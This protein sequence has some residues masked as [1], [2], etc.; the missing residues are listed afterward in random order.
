MA[1]NPR[2]I[3]G[4]PA[5]SSSELQRQNA[6]LAGPQRLVERLKSNYPPGLRVDQDPDAQLGASSGLFTVGA[7]LVQAAPALPRL[8]LQAAPP[9]QEQGD[10]GT[11]D[12]SPAGVEK[13]RDKEDPEA[14]NASSTSL[15]APG[16]NQEAAKKFGTANTF[17]AAH[18]TGGPTARRSQRTATGSVSLEPPP[19][20]SGSSSIKNSRARLPPVED[21]RPVGRKR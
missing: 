14:Y 5:R 1:S 10:V 4:E 8:T 20:V 19:S 13:A 7:G 16:P 17:P 9:A 2:R 12:G 3:K 6:T 15:E 11:P 18:L 21:E